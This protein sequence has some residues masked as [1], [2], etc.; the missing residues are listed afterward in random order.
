MM[1]ALIVISFALLGSAFIGLSYQYTVSEKRE[2][3]ER[4]ADYIAS[5]TAIMQASGTALGDKSYQSY[6]ASLAMISD[7][8][9]VVTQT[10]S[11]VF[12]VTTT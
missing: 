7:A 1:A 8:Y 6:V 11:P 2:S 10:T 9:V 12:C 3:M 5:F 4:N